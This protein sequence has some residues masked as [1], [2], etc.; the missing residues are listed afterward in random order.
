DKQERNE[1]DALRVENDTLRRSLGELECKINQAEKSF[2][3]H[4]ESQ[5]MKENR[6][7]HLGVGQEVDKL[8][9]ILEWLQTA[10]D[11]IMENDHNKQQLV[12]DMRVL[13]TLLVKAKE[14]RRRHDG[15]V[16]SLTRKCQEEEARVFELQEEMKSQNEVFCG[17]LRKDR[18]VYEA[19][20][21]IA[22][23][24]SANR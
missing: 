21:E 23:A 8:N 17:I 7:H 10:K 5:M 9:G 12:G 6:D 14:E 11:D 16:N 13:H 3:A 24:V 18:N 4:T 2:L 19:R 15:I 22:E 1:L 20:T